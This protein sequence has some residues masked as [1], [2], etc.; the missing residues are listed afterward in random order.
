MTNLSA[1]DFTEASTRPVLEE[2]CTQLGLS[3]RGSTLLRL[4]ENAIYRLPSVPV[5]VRIARSMDALE[6]V[7]KE[8]R[9]ALWLAAED[10]PAARLAEHAP[11]AS[12][13]VH[14]RYPVTF[15][16]AITPTEPEPDEVDLGRLLR[17]LH[18]LTPPDSVQLPRSTPFVRVAERLQNAPRSANADDVAYL[19]DLLA[20]L[21]S[22]YAELEFVFPPSAVHGDAHRSNLLRDTSGEVLMLDFEAFAYGHRE[23]DLTVTGIRRNGFQWLSESQ[24]DAFVEANGFDILSWPGFTVLRA[25]RE[26]TMTTW[27]MQLPDD[28]AAAAEFHIRVDDIRASR[29]PRLWKAF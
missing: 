25:I 21:Q 28:P 14:D 17:R 29:Y 20:G 6:D 18:E 16:K 9:V 23:W 27:L 11:E 13:L 5:V 22:R 3:S 26:L 7:R 4:G 12:L 2:A 15:W 24:Y 10:F 19:I 8:V 1:V